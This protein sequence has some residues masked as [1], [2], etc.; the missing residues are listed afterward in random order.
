MAQI[1]HKPGK[2]RSEKAWIVVSAVV[3]VLGAA[4]ILAIKHFND[5]PAI[6]IPNPKMPSPNAFDYFTRAG[7]SVVDGTKV[8][9]A[10]EAHHVPDPSAPY[11]RDYTQ[12]EKEFLVGE[13]AP[14]LKT[15]RQGFAYPYLNLPA[16]SFSALFSYC[17]KERGLARLLTLEGQT[18]GGRGDWGGAVNS[19]LDAVQE[20]EMIP[21]GS[22]L[23]GGL[24][25]MACEAIGRK[26]I[27][28]SYDHLNAEQAQ[29]AARRL[30]EVAPHEI[31][32]ADTM[33][34]EEWLGQA[35]LMEI[36]RAPNWRHQLSYALFPDGGAPGM[37]VRLMF[38]SKR[39]ILNNYT[40]YMNQ[41]VADARKPYAVAPPPPPIPNDPISQMLVPV[42]DKVG[43]KSADNQTQNALL[44]TTLALHAY[45]L[46][47]GTYP[48]T[49]AALAPTYLK[50]VPSDPFARSG[51]LRYHQSGSGYVLYSVGPDGKDDG[52]TAVLDTSQPAPTRPDASDQRRFIKSDSKGDI[53]A[54]VNVY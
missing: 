18:R 40:A 25:G 13:N 21:H 50:A 11:D 9:Y 46:E 35:G 38:M 41:L 47:H 3:G 39:G 44:M 20:G 14:S 51:P 12:A 32:S 1:T 37:E 6:V 30:E 4:G 33:Q 45:H 24:V 36:L 49:L 16:R 52:G 8:G 27:W 31:S 7:S 53:V 29:A 43:L 23:I 28:H 5:L 22:V 10:I 17:A 15:L 42:Y 26:P 19:N 34:E 2:S 48:S 54:G